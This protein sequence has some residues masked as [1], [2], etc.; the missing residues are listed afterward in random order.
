MEK[1]GKKWIIRGNDKLKV[2]TENTIRGLLE[3]MNSNLNVNDER[4]IIPLGHGDPSPFTCFRTTH[5][6][7]DALNTA[8]Q[9]AKFNSYPPPAGIPTARRSIAE[10]LSRDLPYKLST[11]DVFLTSGCRQA[12][13][14]ITTVLAC[15]GGNIL[16]PKPGYPHYDACAV[17][18]NL[19]VRHF[20][21]LPEKA[22]EVDLDAV[23]AL[24]DENTVAIVIINPGNP[25][26]NVY[27]YEHLK[28]VAETAK[29]LGIPVI[30]DEV[31]AHLIFGSNPFVPMGVFGSTVPIFTLGSISKRWIVPGLRLG[32][33]VITDPSGFLKDTEI[34]SLIKQCLNMSTSPACVIQGA[35]PQILENTKEDFFENIISLLCQAIDI[36][37]EEIKEIACITL[38]P[39]PEGS[40]FLMVKLNTVL[41]EDISDDMDFCFKLAKE[42]SVIVLPGAVLGLENW[43]RITFSIDL[44]S[45]K[46]GLQRMKMFCRRHA[47]QQ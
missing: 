28:K 6:V 11:E 44:A 40:M 45:L 2:G 38:L 34:V 22:W 24:A 41:L 29:R 32:W 39:R 15:P 36:C 8:I 21:L 10:H 9:S 19:E 47:K 35:L 7:D 37:Y 20:D 5:I 30:A 23:E 18:H 16:I 13:E 4:P 43:L 26:G 3:V 14:I 12:I 42:E 46:D 33:L 27:T 1:G 31:Y 17:F 25:C